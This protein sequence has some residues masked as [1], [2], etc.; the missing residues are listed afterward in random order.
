MCLIAG[1][2]LWAGCG[3][4]ARLVEHRIPHVEVETVREA[5]LVLGPDASPEMVAFAMLQAMRDD[6]SAGSE[7]ERREALDRELR[8]VDPDYIYGRYKAARGPGAIYQRDDWVYKSVRR[9]APAVAF[10][11][12]SFPQTVE[13]AQ[14][15]MRTGPTSEAEDW[16]GETVQVT[17]PLAHPRGKPNA[18]VVLRMLLHR[19]KSGH[20][21]VFHVGFLKQRP[22]AAAG[23][24]PSPPATQPSQGTAH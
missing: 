18:G 16:P 10:Y 3:K 5:G 11:V 9:W 12:P 24:V 20:W 19:H 6:V 2:G 7:Q 21:R 17:L 14:E 15:V 22:R 13:H 23:R 4:D 1:S 8:L